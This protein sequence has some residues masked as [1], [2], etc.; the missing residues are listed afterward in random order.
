MTNLVVL[1]AAL[2]AVESSGTDRAVDRAG[3]C[4]G[5]LQLKEIYVR[6][7]NRIAG[8]SFVPADRFDRQ[9]SVAMFRI[10]VAHYATR[11]RIGREPTLEDLARIHNR[12]PNGW[13]DPRSEPYWRR[14]KNRMEKGENHGTRN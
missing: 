10:Y 14:V 13:R 3:L 2:I 7:V 1:L 9:K 12:G 4:H 5:P 11:A 6:D 8:T